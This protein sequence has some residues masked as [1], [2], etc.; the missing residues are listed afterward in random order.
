M[1]QQSFATIHSAR[2]KLSGCAAMLLALFVVV[3]CA[4]KQ[5][6]KDKAGP[7]TAAAF[8]A[9]A[10]KMLSLV[11]ASEL[12][13]E[14]PPKD[15]QPAIPI[16]F[17]LEVYSLPLPY[18]TIS[19]NEDFW[20]RINE[21]C[22]SV[23]LYDALYK[24]GIRVGEAPYSE[25]AQFKKVIEENPGVGKKYAVAA[26]T[27]KDIEMAMKQCENQTIWYSDASG[28]GTGR[29][30]DYGATN[31]FMLSF[32]PAPRKIGEVRLKLC[33]VIRENRKRLQINSLNEETEV[34]YVSKQ[35]FFDLALSVDIPLEHFLVI[36]PSPE[37]KWDSSL[38]E[39]FLQ[40]DGGSQKLEQVL[41]VIARP[42]RLDDQNRPT[43]DDAPVVKK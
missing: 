28:V 39:A 4:S 25:F 42:Y 8:D 24:N 41:I 33:P 37:S 19:H 2:N 14:P 10:P 21:Q 1:Q 6:P 23:G 11:Q 20:K 40:Q 22:I 31:L 34:S 5:K 16:L 17:Q 15:A 30:Y 26:T 9:S 36:A 43:L 3:G 29:T 32:Q 35:S 38:G 13:G 27:S 7:T 12:P 18:G